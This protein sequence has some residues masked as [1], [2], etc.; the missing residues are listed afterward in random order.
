[1]RRAELPR[2]RLS[3]VIEEAP[4]DPS[5]GAQGQGGGGVVLKSVEHDGLWISRCEGKPL[6]LDPKPETQNP[7]P[8][9]LNPK[10]CGS[11][12]SRCE[13]A[14]LQQTLE[15]KALNPKPK[16]RN[17]KPESLNPKP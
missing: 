1:M 16:A 4:A 2:I 11:W 15:P 13:G 17:S 9:A 6:T 5:G 7:K 3:F 14:G 12:V 10:S 8:E